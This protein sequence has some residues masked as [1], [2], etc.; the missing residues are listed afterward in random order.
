MHGLARIMAGL[1]ARRGT[2]FPWVPVFLAIGIG[3]W[4]ALPW[5]PGIAFYLS[6]LG[7][8]GAIVALCRLGPHSARPLFIALACVLAGGLAAGLRAHLVQA[9]VLGFRYYGPI[10]GRVIEID[11][12]QA[13]DLRI[14]LD[15][16]VLAR[17]SPQ[18]TPLKVR[19]SLHD[20]SAGVTPAPGL[21]VMLTGHLSAPPG[22]SEP[23]GFDFRRMAFFDQLG[24]VGYSRTPLMALA[25]SEPGTQYINR[26][27]AYLSDAIMAR[28]P[29]QAG[30]FASGAVTGDRSGITQDTVEDLRDSNLS[31]LLAISG[32][33]MAFLTGFVFALCRYGLAL[34]P[35]LALRLNTKKI[36][37]LASLAVAGFYL[38]LSGANVATERAFVMVAVMLAAVLLDRRALSLRTVAIAAVVLLVLRPESLLAPGFQMSF[39][40]TIA[41]IAGFGAL[42]RPA[43]TGGLPRWSRPVMMAVLSSVLAGFATAPL[44]AAHFNRF[45][46][47]GLL[48]NLMTAPAMG[49]FIMP[50]AVMAVLL[51]PIGLS[52]IGLWMMETGSRLILGVAAEVA[53][54]EGAVTGIPAP[55]AWAIPL[56]A[57]GM[58]WVIL[59]R[60]QSRVAGL[61]PAA[62]ALA[63]WVM[64]P[65]PQLLVSGDGAV[66]GLMGPQGRAVSSAK[67]A[68]FAVGSWLENDGD[69][70]DQ[71]Q[72]SVRKGFVGPPEMRSFSVG[73][74]RGV[75]LKGKTGF[76]RLAEACASADFVIVSVRAE[77]VPTGCEVIDA[78]YL[79]KT[80]TLAI[81]Q[82]RTG[83]LVI[84]ATENAD[85]LWSPR[86]KPPPIKIAKAQANSDVRPAITASGSDR[87]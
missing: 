66:V 69:L 70:V 30:A 26:L 42:D 7:G 19:V 79:A 4:F 64:N 37:A 49:I 9:P 48:A 55:G 24:A 72:A 62:L 78:E 12:S 5:E 38:A 53:S 8:F 74:W 54:W 76:R 83:A 14:T 18:R 68:G 43:I 27:R 13:D 16:V 10:E 31:H 34:V 50:G 45:T 47:F 35:P 3:F 63:I 65:R 86:G 41:L 84:E 82:A 77:G 75:A 2:L 67:G 25:P 39:A 11:R 57:L 36:A 46:D 32:M 59:W 6:L 85:R 33:N 44:A 17:T 20:N 61:V 60:G 22:P 51:W 28:L 58:L 71:A 23:D 1:D 21:V 80:G 56:M 29:G 52:G 87:Q 73:T 15:N 81:R 40:A